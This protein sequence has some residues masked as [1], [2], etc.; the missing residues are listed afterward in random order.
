MSVYNICYALVS[1]D[2]NILLNPNVFNVIVYRCLTHKKYICNDL[3]QCENCTF[4]HTTHDKSE[5]KELYPLLNE[6]DI[7]NIIKKC[8][9]AKI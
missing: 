4:T 6:K 8:I 3:N 1:N 2:Y 5:F 7:S 9:S